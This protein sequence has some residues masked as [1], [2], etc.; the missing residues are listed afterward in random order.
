MPDPAYT[1]LIRK[2]KGMFDSKPKFD[3]DVGPVEEL[4]YGAVEPPTIDL[5]NRP[6]H[7]MPDGSVA[8]VRSMG[9]E[10]DG[11]HA[12]LP[13]I[14]HEGKIWSDD[15]A[16]DNYMKTNEHMGL[17]PDDETTDK[18]GELIHQDQAQMLRDRRTDRF[19]DN[20]KW[21]A[22]DSRMRL[23]DKGNANPSPEDIEKEN[24]Q[25]EDADVLLS[26]DL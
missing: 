22:N 12:L 25:H 19:K 5:K 4:K 13:T 9:I 24:K 20:F 8:T 21:L 15:E 1:E 18:A 14:S 2:L 6:E 11:K 7:R 3:V 23:A 26:T 10:H 17:Y 16:F